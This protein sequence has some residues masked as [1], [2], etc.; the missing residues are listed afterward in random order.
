MSLTWQD[1]LATSSARFQAAEVPV[2]DRETVIARYR[3]VAGNFVG[4][5]FAKLPDPKDH[6]VFHVGSGRRSVVRHHRSGCH[7]HPG[8]HR[9]RE[10]PSTL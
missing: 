7:A 9:P 1:G 8:R 3:E 4:P 2:E 6:L 5:C 10:G